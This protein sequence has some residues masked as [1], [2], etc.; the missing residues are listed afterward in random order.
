VQGTE[1]K[2]ALASARQADGSVLVQG[3]QG[4][5][6]LAR[7]GPGKLLYTCAGFLAHPFYAPMVEAAQREIDAAAEL[8]LFVDGWDLHSVDTGFREAWTAW[9]KVHREHFR[10]QL[11]VRTKLMEMAASLAN[12]FTGLS[13]ITTHSSIRSWEQACSKSIP[14]FHR[15]DSTSAPR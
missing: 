6:R 2:N 15:R 8:N 14:G 5:A 4:S 7:L 12:L 9:F 10:M 1:R 11:L 3:A 13:V